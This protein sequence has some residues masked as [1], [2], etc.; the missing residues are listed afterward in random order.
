MGLATASMVRSQH[1]HDDDADG[2]AR[3]KLSELS[4]ALHFLHH[5]FRVVSA[6]GLDVDVLAQVLA[7]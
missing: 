4:R 5:V 2:F 7:Q 1:L 6:V 3:W